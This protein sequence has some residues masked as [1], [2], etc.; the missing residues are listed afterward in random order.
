MF[1]VFLMMI[2]I[3]HNRIWLTHIMEIIINLPNK[4]SCGF[5]GISTIVMQSIKHVILNHLLY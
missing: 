3:I 2:N 1:S 5:D 4:N